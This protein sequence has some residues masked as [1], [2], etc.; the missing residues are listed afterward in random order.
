MLEQ[1]EPSGVIGGDDYLTADY[2]RAQCEAFLESI[3]AEG[4]D[5][6]TAEAHAPG[7]PENPATGAL[8]W[9]RYYQQL[10]RQH[11][12]VVGHGGGSAAG[13]RETEIDRVLAEAAAD[14]PVMVAFD[15]GQIRGVYP[16]SYHALRWLDSLDAQ[17]LGLMEAAAAAMTGDTHN[18]EQLLA[19][20]PLMDSLAV[21]LWF[22][23]LTHPHPDLPFDE[24][25]AGAKPP[26]WTMRA[27]PADRVRVFAAHMEVNHR[28]IR[29]MT[30][31]FP[32]KSGHASRL[33]LSGFIAHVA[34]EKGMAVPLLMR[35]WSLGAL[36]AGVISAGQAARELNDRSEER[37]AK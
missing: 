33:P 13:I 6:A 25:H 12:V 8:G 16:K 21:R 7:A 17:Q 27:S 34:E 18:V 30:S 35:K 29:L 36:F 9:L 24:E 23:I 5:R 1:R 3:I 37:R 14:V 4:G 32:S 15:D 11:A 20:A 2:L 10:N 22:W 19:L 26:K 28:R 31:Y